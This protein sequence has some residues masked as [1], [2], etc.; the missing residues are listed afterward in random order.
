LTD[1]L[2]TIA[3]DGSC[4]NAHA[5]E[6]CISAAAEIERLQKGLDKY[7]EAAEVLRD[8]GDFHNLYRT[9]DKS[10]VGWAKRVLEAS[11]E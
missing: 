10:R 5:E 6:V 11:D 1:K 4:C 7:R 9:Y 2:R 8:F 3:G